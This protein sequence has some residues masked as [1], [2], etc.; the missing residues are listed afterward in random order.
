MSKPTGVP[1]VSRTMARDQA[2]AMLDVVDA[3][4]PGRAEDLAQDPVG[5]LS[6]LPEVAVRSVS[7]SEADAG[8]S[9]AG[10]YLEHEQPPVLAVA[11]S[12]SPGRRGFTALHEYGHHL[13]RT[14]GTL[15]D[16]L[17]EH[18]DQGLA[19]EDA[20][21]DAFA[22]MV[23][24]S[25]ELVAQHIGVRG[26]EA[27]DVVNL[28]RASTASR[29]AACVRAADTLPAPGHVLLVDPAGSLVFAASHGLP[30]L[31]RGSHQ[32]DV[33]VIR[34][35]LSSPRRRAGGKTRLAYRDGIL[36]QELYAQAAD[37]GGYLVV[38]ALTDRVPWEKFTLSSRDA[39]PAGRA[40][41]CEQCGHEFTS[42]KPGCSTCKAPYCP[43][44]S[45][46]GCPSRAAE[47]QCEKCFLTLPLAMFDEDSKRCKECS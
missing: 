30:P 13:Q 20:A 11:A 36:G 32:G 22:A 42:F 14:V 4:A 5:L 45:R 47:R 17:F 40:W 9:V 18:P 41:V 19:L 15:A 21:C 8:C 28:W 2:L 3:V 44:C 46:C 39:G 31:R 24:L 33:Q 10:A 23:L 37:M 7:Q 35:A 1:F 12:L 25:D 26:P 16:R 29:S 27:D 34:Q 6:S 43:E 38:V